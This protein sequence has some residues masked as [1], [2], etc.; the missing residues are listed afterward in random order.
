MRAS[1]SEDA[2]AAGPAGRSA[3]AVLRA[4]SYEDDLT[5]KILEGA[6]LC[7]LDVR[8]KRCC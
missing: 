1:Q 6:R 5:A 2:P 7:G 8:G 3:V 4:A